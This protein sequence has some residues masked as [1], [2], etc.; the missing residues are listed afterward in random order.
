MV[1]SSSRLKPG[2]EG[3]IIATVDIKGK[4]GYITKTVKV[5]TNDPKRPVVTL[6]LKALIKA[7]PASP[8]QSPSPSQPASP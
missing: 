4:I 5:F 2:E 6:V 3:K 1:A 7:Q 8:A